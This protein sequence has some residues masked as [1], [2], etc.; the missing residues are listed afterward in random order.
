MLLTDTHAHA[1]HAGVS[2]AIK[3]LCQQQC[4]GECNHGWAFFFFFRC[5][6]CIT[7]MIQLVMMMMMIGFQLGTP[8]GTHR[9]SF[10]WV[11]N[12]MC[13]NDKLQCRNCV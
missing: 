10:E 12:K 2:Y 8:L 3:S 9:W 11:R 6:V 5:A 1:G 13:V 7:L 4:G